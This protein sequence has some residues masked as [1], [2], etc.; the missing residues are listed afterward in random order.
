M[1]V[2]DAET[3]YDIS[4]FPG[5]PERLRGYFYLNE[6]VSCSGIHSITVPEVVTSVDS[7]PS[8]YSPAARTEF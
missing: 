4:S 5:S 1:V 7:P 3:L 6:V 2:F 8:I